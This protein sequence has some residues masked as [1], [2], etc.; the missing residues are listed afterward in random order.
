MSV[1]ISPTDKELMERGSLLASFVCSDP[2][3][4]VAF[5]KAK[6]S[7]NLLV[8]LEMEIPVKLLFDT[9]FLFLHLG[10]HSELQKKELSSGR[11][12]VSKGQILLTAAEQTAVKGRGLKLKEIAACTRLG[13][14]TVSETVDFLVKN[15][16]LTRQPSKQDRRAIEVDLCEKGK[17]FVTVH[18]ENMKNLWRQI[19]REIDDEKL[20]IFSE[21]LTKIF[22]QLREI[23]QKKCSS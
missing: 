2:T 10:A 7:V 16:L 5:V 6:V 3:S 22:Q 14:S 1:E 8:E 19:T 21:V 12:S 11:V 18:N 20:N 13:M 15:D 17:T 4:N 23:E 9:T